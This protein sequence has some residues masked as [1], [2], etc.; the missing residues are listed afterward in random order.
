[1]LKIEYINTE[2][3][4]SNFSIVYSYIVILMQLIYLVFFQPLVLSLSLAKLK[5]KTNG[6]DGIMS[7]FVLVPCFKRSAI[8][9]ALLGIVYGMK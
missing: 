9:V 8:H 7:C 1:M 3:K 2:N 5:D 6:G 4:D